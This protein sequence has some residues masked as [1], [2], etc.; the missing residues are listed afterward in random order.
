MTRGFPI[1]RNQHWRVYRYIPKIPSWSRTLLPRHHLCAGA[2]HAAVAD[3]VGLQLRSFQGLRRMQLPLA[4]DKKM[5]KNVENP[6]W[7]GE[8]TRFTLMS[9]GDMEK[10]CALRTWSEKPLVF[11]HVVY[12][13]APIKHLVDLNIDMGNQ[14]QKY[15]ELHQKHVT[16]YGL[17]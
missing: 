17:I 9:T 12:C 3:Y 6:W 4:K 15:D 1:L 13:I 10:T 5:Q 16:V 11:R 8:L 14:Q 2:N 7:N